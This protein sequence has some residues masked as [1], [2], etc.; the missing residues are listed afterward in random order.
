MEAE[1][2]AEEDDASGVSSQLSSTVRSAASYNRSGISSILPSRKGGGAHSYY[3]DYSASPSTVPAAAT[4]GGGW[5]Q[6][7]SLLAG[8][9]VS[10]SPAK[11]KTLMRLPARPPS[12]GVSPGRAAGGSKKQPYLPSYL[13]Y[14]PQGIELP[15][16]NSS[17]SSLTPSPSE[18]QQ[19]LY[20]SKKKRKA[21]AQDTELAAAFV[22]GT[23][24]APL[25]HTSG[26]PPP[27]PH[28]G[29]PMQLQQH[30]VLLPPRGGFQAPETSLSG[31]SPPQQEHQPFAGAAAGLTAAV[32]A[33]VGPPVQ[34]A[35][36]AA[37]P[38]YAFNSEGSHERKAKKERK[39]KAA[40]AK[41]R[42]RDSSLQ[43][44]LPPQETLP[45]A[46]AH[47]P[48]G[49]TSAQ[50]PPGVKPLRIRLSF[51]S[52]QQSAAAAPSQQ[53]PPPPFN[54]PQLPAQ[55]STVPYDLQQQLLQQPLH[56]QAAYAPVQHPAPDRQQHPQQPAPA[57]P[58][59]FRIRLP[60]QPPQ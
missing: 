8:P 58:P 22:P 11:R 49:E 56:G 5:Q 9:E 34:Q 44:Q 28:Q 55:P 20:P 21:A 41:K 39:A 1:A 18:Q 15:L 6:Q 19:Q 57:A 46:A 10:E 12:A 45:L 3:D 23:A 4:S 43:E 2:E 54:Q 33:P 37:V 17:K 50:R 51:G 42:G 16:P 29:L 40:K 14:V 26:A 53:L 35:F 13:G 38:G 32:S 48:V 24:A 60:T 59:K 30:P 31:L 7:K 27:A 52:Q 25:P 47:H 36:G